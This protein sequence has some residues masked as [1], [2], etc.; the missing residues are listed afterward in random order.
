[1]TTTEL[2]D[3]QFLSLVGKAKRLP[4]SDFAKFNQ[5]CLGFQ[6]KTKKGSKIFKDQ[7]FNI[8]CENLR[9]IEN[10]GFIIEK[11]DAEFYEPAK[12]N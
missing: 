9:D 3:K 10:L 12:K 1:M 11:R 7:L 2:T 8:G 5:N 6:F 4:F